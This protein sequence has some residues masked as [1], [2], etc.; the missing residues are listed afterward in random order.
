MLED[1]KVL[2]IDPD[3]FGMQDFTSFTSTA[4]RYTHDQNLYKYSRKTYS[5]L[6]YLRDLGGLLSS[7][8]GLF[9]VLVF[10]VNFE[11]LYQW[12]TSSLYRVQSM[13]D[14]IAGVRR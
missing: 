8:N 1:N 9:T 10:I 6:D 14:H 2:Y 3:Y 7:V 5:F 11:G 13:T 4:V 12:L